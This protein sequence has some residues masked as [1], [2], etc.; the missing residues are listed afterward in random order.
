[1]ADDDSDWSQQSSDDEPELT[2]DELFQVLRNNSDPDFTGL[3][4]AP[5]PCPSR[6]AVLGDAM[7]FN[8]TVTTL[9]MDV[10]R[11]NLNGEVQ[12]FVVEQCP[13]L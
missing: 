8:T 1:M 9:Y 5:W 6:D 11:L 12:T 2:A 7:P 10:D 4:V 3:N 13:F